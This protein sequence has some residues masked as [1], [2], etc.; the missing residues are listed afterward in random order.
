MLLYDIVVR[1]WKVIYIYDFYIFTL[2][3]T[4]IYECLNVGMENSPSKQTRCT[5][6]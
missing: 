5:V 2:F 6:S 1:N 3:V 4:C